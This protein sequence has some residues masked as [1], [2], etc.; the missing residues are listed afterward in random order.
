MAGRR[1]R[2]ASPTP[3]VAQPRIVERT[4]ISRA[5]LGRW[6]R[7]RGLRREERPVRRDD[8]ALEPRADPGEVHVGFVE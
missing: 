4:E 1:G 5:S 8:V 2:R 3:L 6:G 7:E